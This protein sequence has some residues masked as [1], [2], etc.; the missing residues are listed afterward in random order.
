MS[1]KK[2]AFQVMLAHK[3]SPKRVDA[4]SEMVA[5]PKLDGVRVITHCDSKGARFYSRNGRQL[6]M[7]DNL[8]DQVEMLRKR[9]GWKTVMLDGEMTSK[10]FADIA[11]TIHRKNHTA[12]DAKYYVFHAMPVGL[13]WQ[14]EDHMEYRDRRIEMKKAFDLIGSP[15]GFRIWRLPAWKV[16][17]HAAVME[18]YRDVLEEG[19]EGLIV[20]HRRGHWIAKRDYA[21]MK[22]KEEITVDAV[23]TGIKEG[24]G[25]YA[26][27]CGALI[28]DYKGKEVKVSGMT[29]A[30]RALF[31]AKPKS[32]VGHMVEVECQLIT[33]AGSLR[34][35]RFKRIRDDKEQRWE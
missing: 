17:S 34:H 11:G 29:D 9:L 23:V 16:E 2:L 15:K 31:W 30:Q 7:F 8:A 13:F 24:T 1:T 6:F 18:V 10:S 35:P 3:Y 26:N 33:E 14:G 22:V 20:K 21:W 5:E 28:I 25:K 4:W 27:N 19:Y 12:E 32:V